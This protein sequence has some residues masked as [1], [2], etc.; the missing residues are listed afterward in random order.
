MSIPLPTSIISDEMFPRREQSS[1][2][3]GATRTCRQ[4]C[5]FRV[6]TTTTRNRQADKHAVAPYCEVQCIGNTTLG[7]CSRGC[8]RQT[9]EHV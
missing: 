5:E 7:S 1:A 8:E 6:P 9:I 2:A 3:T 4:S